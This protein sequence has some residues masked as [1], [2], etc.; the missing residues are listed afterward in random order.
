MEFIFSTSYA[1]TNGEIKRKRNRRRNSPTTLLAFHYICA[2]LVIIYGSCCRCCCGGLVVNVNIESYIVPESE[3]LA[4]SMHKIFISSPI[5]RVPVLLALNLLLLLLLS[6][7]TLFLPFSFLLKPHLTRNFIWNRIICEF[8]FSNFK[9]IMS[10]KPVSF[11]T[12]Q[13]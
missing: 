8:S 3:W 9:T 7:I 13:I 5:P 2:G 10:P 11:N 6:S 12:G 1:M 4:P